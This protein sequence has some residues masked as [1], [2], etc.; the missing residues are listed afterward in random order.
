MVGADPVEVI[1]EALDRLGDEDW[2]G[3]STA[4]MTQRVVELTSLSARVEA[5]AVGRVGRWEAAG[6]WYVGGARSPAAALS[7]LS[8]RTKGFCQKLVQTGRLVTHHATTAKAVANGDLDVDKA[9]RLGRSVTDLRRSIY[10]R[11]EETLVEAGG[12]LDHARFRLLVDRWVELADDVVDPDKEFD[13]AERRGLH[14]GQMLDGLA[15]IAGTAEP[16]GLA[17]IN[18]AIDAYRRP[19]AK[20]TPG[21]GRSRA[22]TDYDA[23]I[24][25]LS[26]A[27]DGQGGRPERTVDAIVSY[28]L[29]LRL[30]PVDLLNVRCD[31]E[32]VGAV[33]P[34]LLRRLAADS[35]IGRLITDADGVPLDLGRRVRFFKPT[36]RRAVRVRDQC[37]VWPGCGL[38]AEWS[39]IDHAVQAA[40]GGPTDV[41]NGRLL[42]RFHHHLRDK[43]WAITHDPATGATEVT[44][45]IGITWTDDG[46]VRV[47]TD[48]DPPRPRGP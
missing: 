27:I 14:I 22:K 29:L 17:I 16:E 10:Q 36:Q 2:A 35:A 28:E 46:R 24:A 45:P 42:C 4:A 37:C 30:P 7:F 9:H 33:S 19:D 47:P 15:A 40:R 23:L 41:A 31:L 21:G 26:A 20:G 8:G 38:P 44:N 3:W 43:G 1:R 5:V 32:G 25:A 34:S 39:D 13:R 48:P 11:D 18:R 12:E 6:G